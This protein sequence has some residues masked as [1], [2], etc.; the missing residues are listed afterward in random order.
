MSPRGPD[1]PCQAVALRGDAVRKVR[2]APCLHR[3]HHAQGVLGHFLLDQ[4]GGLAP[5]EL[6]G[7]VRAD[8][9]ALAAPMQVEGE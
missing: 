6:N 9:E 7:V 8:G 5:V 1:R 2:W 3:L 4:V